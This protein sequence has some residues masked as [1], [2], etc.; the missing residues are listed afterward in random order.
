MT[1]GFSTV[2]K[3]QTQGVLSRRVRDRLLGHSTQTV[4]M[5][6]G[7]PGT[8]LRE[9]TEISLDK[10]DS[11]LESFERA[12]PERRV[13]KRADPSA[14]PE[15]MYSVEVMT[16]RCT[17]CGKVF[18]QES[19]L[20]HLE[21]RFMHMVGDPSI[22]LSDEAI[23]E[24]LKTRALHNADPRTSM[25]KLERLIDEEFEAY[26][27]SRHQGRTRMN[28][29]NA[30]RGT[31]EEQLGLT[32]DDLGYERICCRMYITASLPVNN[33]YKELVKGVRVQRIMRIPTLASTGRIS[34]DTRTVPLT[35]TRGLETFA[36]QAGTG[37]NLF[38]ILDTV[39]RQ[40]ESVTSGHVTILGNIRTL[41]ES[42]KKELSVRV[43]SDSDL[44]FVLRAKF[45]IVDIIATGNTENV[46][47]KIEDA[48]SYISDVVIKNYV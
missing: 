21:Y 1:G 4:I 31:Q 12:M 9:R 40:V 30:V 22:L 6:E 7:N 28:L 19:I 35:A 33:R 25:D 24:Y 34:I 43:E 41:L 39:I 10:W 13:I 3:S 45:P 32:M 38:T 20:D 23:L 11:I 27:R 8:S 47:E 29:E 26:K 46:D 37:Y 48:V 16:V 14:R 15:D 17:S 5:S 18:K 2:P 44:D 36:P 42:N